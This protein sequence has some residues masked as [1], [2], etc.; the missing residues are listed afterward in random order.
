M[1][2]IN[3]FKLKD[4]LIK[5]PVEKMANDMRAAKASGGGVKEIGEI[6]KEGFK[7]MNDEYNKAVK[8]YVAVAATVVG[9]SAVVDK[10]KEAKVYK[11]EAPEEIK[12]P[13]VEKQPRVKAV[14]PVKTVAPVPKVDP[15]KPIKAPEIKPIAQKFD[16][17]TLIKPKKEVGKV[18]DFLKD[19]VKE[20]TPSHTMVG[21]IVAGET[22]GSVM[23][24]ATKRLVEKTTT[25]GVPKVETE[26][27]AVPAG[28]GQSQIMT[29]LQNYWWVGIVFVALIWVVPAIIK[30]IKGK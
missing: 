6:A 5:K 27:A 25:P 13:K 30:A 19:F 24:S 12:P 8:P 29:I 11:T 15:I 1:G 3:P 21:R 18:G 9:A 2:L 23:G 28:G 10:V 20:A 26:T 7:Q 16:T 17:K 4:K 14:E 22:A